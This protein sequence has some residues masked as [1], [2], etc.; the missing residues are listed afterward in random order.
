VN[1]TSSSTAAVSVETK[2]KTIIFIDPNEV[3]KSFVEK[4]SEEKAHNLKTMSLAG[5]QNSGGDLAFFNY[6]W[7]HWGEA[8]EMFVAY[9]QTFLAQPHMKNIMD[10]E[11]LGGDAALRLYLRNTYRQQCLDKLLELQGKNATAPAV[12]VADNFGHTS[13]PTRTSISSRTTKTTPDYPSKSVTPANVPTDMSSRVR[14]VAAAQCNNKTRALA[15]K[16]DVD[17]K[18][19]KSNRRYPLKVKPCRIKVMPPDS[20]SSKLD[21]KELDAALKSVRQNI[22]TSLRIQLFAKNTCLPLL[23][24]SIMLND[25]LI[26]LDLSNERGK[27]GNAIKHDQLTQLLDAFEARSTKPIPLQKLSLRGNSLELKLPDK[28]RF[29]FG[30]DYERDVK[31]KAKFDKHSNQTIAGIAR[32][33]KYMTSGVMQLTHLD[34]SN[35]DLP[36]DCVSSLLQL[37]TKVPELIFLDITGNNIDQN[38]LKLNALVLSVADR[39]PPWSSSATSIDNDRDTIDNDRDT[40]AEKFNS[41]LSQFT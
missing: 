21:Q 2:A 16:A 7:D 12:D 6:F 5:Y 37:K 38:N 11:R 15:C 41:L 35:M 10:Y 40:I 20:Y 27:D 24:S 8:G 36:N 39:N 17:R 23:F 32:L 31:S 14:N 22:C 1:V 29:T 28:L 18:Q 3:V 9:K 33:C 26:E 34:L 13:A 19:S 4:F 30:S 25:S